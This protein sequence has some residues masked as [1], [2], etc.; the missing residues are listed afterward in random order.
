MTQSKIRI[1]N[2]G[3][4]NLVSNLRGEIGENIFSW[5]LMRNLKVQARRLRTDDIAHDMKN[6]DLTILYIVIDKL[7]DEIIARLS[8]LAEKKVGQLTF[9]FV[10][11][12]L[13]LFKR[14]VDEFVKFIHSNRFHEKRNYNISHKQLPEKWSG[15]KCIHIPYRRIVK[16]LV[17]ALRLMKKIDRIALGPSAPFLWREMRKR[18]YVPVPSAKVAYMLLPYLCLSAKERVKIVFLEAMENKNTWVDM[19]TTIDG[20]PVAVQACKKWG[21]VQWG[22]SIIAL[23]QYPLVEIKSLQTKKT[24]VAHNDGEEVSKESKCKEKESPSVIPN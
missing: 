7:E 19:K 2:T 24:K 14:E 16:G 15:H 22:N 5:I 10:Q 17:H 9:Y 13:C 20:S 23:P 12:K 18:R 4:D 1:N 11:E 21:V 8:E 6:E 3:L